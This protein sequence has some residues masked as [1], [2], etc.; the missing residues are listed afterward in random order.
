MV[1][2]QV[3]SRQ[4]SKD[5]RDFRKCIQYAIG[6]VSRYRP[7]YGRT[8]PPESSSSM[9]S[10]DIPPPGGSAVMTYD[11]LDE[12]DD[13]VLNGSVVFSGRAAFFR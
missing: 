5:E 3:D 13:G 8:E 6:G 2:T 7:V 11:S 10:C 9:S 12:L 1:T 4:D